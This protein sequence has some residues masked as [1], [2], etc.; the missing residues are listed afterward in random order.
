MSFPGSWVGVWDKLNSFPAKKKRL[1]LIEHL[2]GARPLKD[3]KFHVFV[4]E[5]V[6]PQA[7]NYYSYLQM[8][9]LRLEEE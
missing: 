9:K 6:L 5:I 1:I 2:Q 4:S 8:K 3:G 7:C